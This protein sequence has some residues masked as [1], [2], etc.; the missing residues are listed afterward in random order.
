MELSTCHFESAIHRAMER[1]RTRCA[2]LL[3][4]AKFKYFL[5]GAILRVREWTRVRRNVSLVGRHWKTL[6][7][8]TE[9]HFKPIF[10]LVTDASE[11]RTQKRQKRKFYNRGKRSLAHVKPS[12]AIRVR[13]PRGTW[14][15]GVCLREL[16]PRSYNIDVRVDGKFVGQNRK[17]IWRTNEVQTPLEDYEPPSSQSLKEVTA[18]STALLPLAEPAMQFLV[19][20]PVGTAPYGHTRKMLGNVR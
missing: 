8:N 1:R 18:E 14:K 12:E 4:S 11:L 10:S 20:E 19:T 13:F 17:D 5:M 6:F 15:L 2:E 16:A 7:P 3:V 9:A